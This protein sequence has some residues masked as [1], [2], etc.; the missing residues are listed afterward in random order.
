VPSAF[1]QPES[2]R[3]GATSFGMALNIDNGLLLTTPPD[4][5]ANSGEPVLEVD[6]IVPSGDEGAQGIVVQVA[7]NTP[8]GSNGVQGVLIFAGADGSAD[9][10]GLSVQASMAAAGTAG[11]FAGSFDA[12]NRGSGVEVAVTGQAGHFQSGANAL[13]FEGRNGAGAVVFQVRSDGN[14]HIKTGAT[15]TADL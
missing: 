14:I 5:F 6:Q 4:S 8:S 7:D 1:S 13:C 15:V 12:A 9:V 3:D 10:D 11:V 2:S